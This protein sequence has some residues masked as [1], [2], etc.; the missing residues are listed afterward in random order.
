[1]LV[2]FPNS[3]DPLDRVVA[4]LLDEFLREAMSTFRVAAPRVVSTT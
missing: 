1:M 2:S 3:L 4:N